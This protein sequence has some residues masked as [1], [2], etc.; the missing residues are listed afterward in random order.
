MEAFYRQQHPRLKQF[1]ARRVV[2]Q[3]EVED[4]CQEIWR[5]FFNR[6]EVFRVDY[7]DPAQALYP[8][9]RCRIADFWKQRT[10]RREFLVAGE[11]LVELA[12]KVRLV[13][14]DEEACQLWDLQQALAAL[15][16][17]QREALSLRYLE[18][19]SVRITATE[20]GVSENTVKKHLKDGLTALRA[21]PSLTFYRST[22]AVAQEVRK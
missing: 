8:I 17:R 21:L 15:P 12:Q 19:L 9:A 20:M 5:I 22:A 6:F 14:A 11:D 1:V 10:G 13:V 18:D 3:G 7:D 2:G 16:A 4:V